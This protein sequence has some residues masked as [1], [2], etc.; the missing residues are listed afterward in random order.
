MS[1]SAVFGYELLLD[2]YDC[3][4]GVCDDLTLCYN[5]L[6]EIVGFLGM[7]KQAPPA[8]FRSDGVRFAHLLVLL[9]SIN[10][11]VESGTM[12]NFVAATERA[13]G[14]PLSAALRRTASLWSFTTF[15]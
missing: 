9:R 1:K 7:E 2:L 13:S 5:F 3:K 15:I 10:E 14:D 8:I 11:G 6:D 4:P 12:P